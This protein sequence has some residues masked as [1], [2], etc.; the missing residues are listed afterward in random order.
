MKGECIITMT[1]S[2]IEMVIAKL[3]KI[4]PKDVR[5]SVGHTVVGCGPMEREEHHVIAKINMQFEPKKDMF[6]FGKPN[7]P[8]I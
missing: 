5:L 8:S 3:L 6:E 2:E 1:G 7:V 4:E